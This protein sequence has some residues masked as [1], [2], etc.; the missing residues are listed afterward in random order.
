MP[1]ENEKYDE[2]DQEVL[3][4]LNAYSP[5]QEEMDLDAFYDEWEKQYDDFQ[6]RKLAKSE[7]LEGFDWEDLEDTS[8]YDDETYSIHLGL[9]TKTKE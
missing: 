3:D 7:V 4:N 1:K 8:F 9:P 5:S 6:K 2:L